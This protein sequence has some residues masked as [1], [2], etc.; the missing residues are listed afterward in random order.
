ME[1]LAGTPD[2]S[3]ALT[4]EDV[5]HRKQFTEYVEHDASGWHRHHLGRLLKLWREWNERYFQGKLIAPHVLLKTPNCPTRLGEYA[6]ISAWGSKGQICLR[7]SL[8]SG[9]YPRMREGGEYAEGRFLFLADVFM[10]ETIHQYQYEVVEDGEDAYRGHGPQFAAICNRIGDY[11]GLP[12]VRVAKKRGPNAH[13]PS[14]AQW[15]HNV[16]SP[17]YYMRAWID[18]DEPEETPEERA[19]RERRVQRATL[20]QDVLTRCVAYGEAELHH[21]DEPDSDEIEEALFDATDELHAV[22]IEFC[23]H[24]ALAVSKLP[25]TPASPSTGTNPSTAMEVPR[26]ASLDAQGSGATN[27]T[28][29]SRSEM[30]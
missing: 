30:K 19:D 25:A 6:T 7:P 23:L 9:T 21:Q 2:V 3:L 24:E 26:D 14:C 15:P 29:R 4:P 10:H 28:H 22:A 18:D 20:I 16:R 13:L 11:L 12:S 1:Q 5:T 17:E 8:L 27:G